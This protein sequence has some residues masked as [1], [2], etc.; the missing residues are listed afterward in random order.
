MTSRRAESIAV[1]SSSAVSAVTNW[2][3]P[4]QSA[5]TRSLSMAA[6]TWSGTGLRPMTRL[7]PARNADSVKI[8][9]PTW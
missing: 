6:A 8:W 1:A 5:V 9:S 7:P 4:A 2:G 3:D